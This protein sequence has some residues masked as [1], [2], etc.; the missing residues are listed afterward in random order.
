MQADLKE[1]IAR[2]NAE[3]AK[4]RTWGW[5]SLGV[6]VAAAAFSGVSVYLSDLAYRDYLSTHDTAAAAYFHQRVVLW[7]TLLLVSAGAGVLG[8]GVSIPFFALG[9]DVRTEREALKK[10]ESEM[11]SLALPEGIGK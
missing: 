9:P 8:V 6:G 11:A 4:T 10:V 3:R 7:D 1:S 2:I 5:M